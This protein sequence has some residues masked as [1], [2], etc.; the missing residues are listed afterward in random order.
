MYPKVRA[1]NTRCKTAQERKERK[2]AADRRWKRKNTEKLL[3]YKRNFMAKNPRYLGP[4]RQGYVDRYN[5]IKRAPCK[6]C[7]NSYFPCCMQFDHLGDK[8][9]TSL[10]WFRNASHGQR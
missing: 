7:G 4:T 5:E 10:A 9:E 6:D 2:R 3:Q 8:V 1:S